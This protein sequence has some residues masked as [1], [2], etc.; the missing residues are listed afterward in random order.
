ML[1]IDKFPG[2]FSLLVLLLHLSLETN[3]IFIHQIFFFQC[4]L[5]FD[6]YHEV[7]VYILSS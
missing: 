6:F 3:Y 5:L 2:E 1:I 7:I 4:C